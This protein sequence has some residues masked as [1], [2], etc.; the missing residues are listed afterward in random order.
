LWVGRRRDEQKRFLV[1]QLDVVGATT[2]KIILNS[3]QVEWSRR[4]RS[5]QNLGQ[6]KSTSRVALY[7]W[8]W[9]EP[10]WLLRS[11][12]SQ[13]AHIMHQS[14]SVISQT[15]SRGLRKATMSILCGQ[16]S[17]S[18]AYSDWNRRG[19]AQVPGCLGSATLFH[20]IPRWQ[21]GHLHTITNTCICTHIHIIIHIYL[22]I[23]AHITI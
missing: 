5:N 17:T 14:P 16:D 23:H 6:K 19:S 1:S 3:P 13:N 8:S 18:G 4:R 2:I 7:I 9:T 15:C 12:E 22:Y 10:R 21:F 11:F 20:Y